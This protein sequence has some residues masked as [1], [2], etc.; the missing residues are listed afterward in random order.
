MLFI[1]G[2]PTFF[3]ELVVGQYA[4]MAATKVYAR[5]SPGLRGLGYGMVSI[6]MLI[7]FQYVVIMA[8]AMYYLFA[9]F[10]SE[11]P[12][13]SCDPDFSGDHCYDVSKAEDCGVNEY[14]YA[15][16]CMDGEEFCALYDSINLR[17]GTCSPLTYELNTTSTDIVFRDVTYRVSPSEEYWYNHV[18]NIAVENGH[19]DTSINSWSKWG[20]MRWEILGC[21]AAS[22]AICCLFLIQ[23]IASYGKV[24]YFTTLFPYV[25]LTISLGYVATLDGFLEGVRYYIVPTDWSKLFDIEVWND[26]AGQI[27]YSLGVAVGSHLLL[28]SYNDFR[29]NCHRDAILIGLCNSLTSFYAGFTVF[30]VIGYIAKEK[31]EP[32]ENVVTQGPGLAFIVYPEAV[33]LMDVPPL[34]SFLFFFMLCLLAISSVC[35]TWEGLMGAIL[36]E[37]PSLRN[38]RP[39][40]TMATMFG[41]FLCGISMCFDSGFLMFTLM[42]NRCAASILLM[43]FVELVT[44]SYFYGAGTI[45]RHARQMGMHLHPAV[46]TFWYVCWMFLTPL[47]V[48]IITFLAWIYFEPDSLEDYEYPPAAQF[49]GWALELAPVGVV[50]LGAIITV[51]KRRRAGKT[52]A[53]IKPGPLMRP[54]KLW[55]PR[56]DSGLPLHAWKDN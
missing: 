15:Y 25:V 21:L 12:W 13:S 7:N 45:L 56:A 36:D 49:L 1:I 24:V 40:V 31:G 28:A 47:I 8:Y 9:G 51:F 32:I 20:G 43:A 11:L 6:P 10:T 27:Y 38:K 54:N 41:G 48:G 19:L 50:V 35:G 39:Y 55:G 30:G 23:G 44:M 16:G 2:L 22:W 33:S 53:F 18:L 37:F 4:G 5:M 46:E 29:S 42:D 17:E 26:A 52:W 3:M 14:Y 34:F